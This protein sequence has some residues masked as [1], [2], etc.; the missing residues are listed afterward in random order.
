[1]SKFDKATRLQS[2]LADMLE[3]NFKDTLTAIAAE[4]ERI[5]EGKAAAG[6]GRQQAEDAGGTLWSSVLDL[7]EVTEQA[8]EAR[9]LDA[10]QICDVLTVVLNGA[11]GQIKDAAKAE[12]AAKSLKSYAST[13]RKVTQ[14]VR[15]GALNWH[16]TRTK[17][18]IDREGEPGHE[19]S[20]S[21]SEVRDMLK[22]AGQKEVD[23]FRKIASDLLAKIAGKEND[24][25][26]ASTRVASLERVIEFLQPLADEA[27]R[28]K[29]S[30]KKVT[31]AAKAANTARQVEH[32]LT[33][34]TTV[35]TVPLT[36]NG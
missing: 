5:A 29:E 35:E 12:K 18:V 22:S 19:E 17:L 33:T 8:E 6:V 1:M 30:S 10:D 3:A 21:Y 32:A 36:V 7:A 9:E 31:K 11:L 23:S 20:V 34:P 16:Q 15:R 27:K 14:A 28:I 13:A 26:K 25:R 2:D 4:A 24:P